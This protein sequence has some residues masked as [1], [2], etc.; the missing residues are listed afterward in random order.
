[1]PPAV[2][3]L[4][5]AAVKDPSECFIPPP[6]TPHSN[7]INGDTP[8]TSAERFLNVEEKT[9]FV[10]KATAESLILLGDYLLIV[11]NLELVV[12]DVMVRIIEFLKASLTI[13]S[14][15]LMTDPI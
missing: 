4:L 2:N 14:T 11:I 1:M 12:T 5:A 7:G 10:V 6:S 8:S 13:E 15:R 9:F 3:N